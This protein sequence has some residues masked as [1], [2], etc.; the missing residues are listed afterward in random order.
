MSRKAGLWKEESAIFYVVFAQAMTFGKASGSRACHV[1]QASSAV[2][3]PVSMQ[4]TET[5]SHFFSPHSG[6][7]L[8]FFH[9]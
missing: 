3:G 4:V 9:S 1:S 7:L 6:C 2:D 5:R 8:W